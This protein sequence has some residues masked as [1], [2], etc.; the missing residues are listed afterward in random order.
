M[1]DEEVLAFLR[2]TAEQLALLAERGTFRRVPG[3]PLLVSPVCVE[4]SSPDI[5]W[6]VFRITDPV[7]NYLLVTN[8]GLLPADWEAAVHYV[9]TQEPW[10][11]PEPTGLPDASFPMG[12]TN[13]V[14][15]MV[16]SAPGVD[17]LV[18]DLFRPHSVVTHQMCLAVRNSLLAGERLLDPPPWFRQSDCTLLQVSSTFQRG[19]NVLELVLRETG[20][21]SAVEVRRDGPP[22]YL[23]GLERAVLVRAAGDATRLEPGEMAVLRTGDRLAI[24]L[25]PP[26]AFLAW[27]TFVRWM[28]PGEV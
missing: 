22:E 13:A 11:M 24:V 6:R 25:R 27:Q 9:G 28:L 20:P 7:D 3:E 4:V 23:A 12:M 19:R 18:T 16:A 2:P 10:T 17:F 14:Y 5:D 26:A 15:V 21:G 1:L 8:R